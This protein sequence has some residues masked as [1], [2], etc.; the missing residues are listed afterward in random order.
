MQINFNG[1]LFATNNSVK[2][3]RLKLQDENIMLPISG[4][5]NIILT[6]FPSCRAVTISLVAEEWYIGHHPGI[7]L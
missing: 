2:V 1:M 4:S 6:Y 5:I 7:D 3:L